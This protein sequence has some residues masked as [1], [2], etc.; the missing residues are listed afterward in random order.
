MDKQKF[1]D[2]K[3]V[4]FDRFLEIIETMDYPGQK[5]FADNFFP[6][7]FGSI[8]EAGALEGTQE[9]IAFRRKHKNEG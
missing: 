2:E 9:M 3:K 4:Q 1:M 8:Y 6:S 7:F 5:E